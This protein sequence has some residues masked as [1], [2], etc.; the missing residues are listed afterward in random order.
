MKE[1]AK[2]PVAGDA[3]VEPALSGPKSDALPLGLPPVWARYLPRAL[4]AYCLG[5]PQI[6]VRCSRSAGLAR[7]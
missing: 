7:S 4:A 3:G 5:L 1:P 2:W 6:L